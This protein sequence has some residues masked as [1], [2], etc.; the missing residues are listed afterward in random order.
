MFV[1]SD[2][3]QFAN[4]DEHASRTLSRKTVAADALID[5]VRLAIETVG[6]VGYTRSSRHR[7]ALPRRPRL[8]VPPAR[9]G[10]A[11]AV[12]RP[13]GAGSQPDRLN[14]RWAGP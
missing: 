3:L 6:G 1:D 8:P 12:Q 11:D 2:N 10:Q 7:A 13:G 9:P 4:T 5:T 14:R